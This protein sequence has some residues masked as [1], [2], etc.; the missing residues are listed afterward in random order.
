MHSSFTCIYYFVFDG[1]SGQRLG[2]GR[3]P[4]NVGLAPQTTDPIDESVISGPGED[5]VAD[6][7]PPRA[8]PQQ[9][10]Q[11]GLGSTRAGVRQQVLVRKRPTSSSTVVEREQQ[12]Q[13]DVT[14]S[15]DEAADVP[16]NSGVR[17]R[18]RPVFAGSR[19]PQFN[20]NR[21]SQTSD[22]PRGS[23]KCKTHARHKRRRQFMLSSIILYQPY[24]VCGA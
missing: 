8:R 2:G 1:G 6:V 12:Q 16:L 19:G 7:R 3:G 10:Q 23:G 14:S 5:S 9:Q 22:E 20:R 11:P 15:L 4:Q 18:Q 21:Q 13:Q 24:S 17:Q